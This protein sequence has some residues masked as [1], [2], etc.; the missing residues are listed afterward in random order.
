ME[1]TTNRIRKLL[2]E[3]FASVPCPEHF[4][5]ASTVIPHSVTRELRRDFYNY[6]PE[7][8]RYLLPFVLEDL[9]DTRTGDDIETDDAEFLVMQLDPLLLDSEITRKTKLKQFA[10]FTLDQAQAV[11][12]WLRMARTWNDLS[13]FIDY[14][15]RAIQYWCNRTSGSGAK[16]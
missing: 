7:E 3:A 1:Q 6:E 5:S 9:M 2:R 8:V 4:G 11:C 12:E 16:N 10:G 15:D 14:V 13:R